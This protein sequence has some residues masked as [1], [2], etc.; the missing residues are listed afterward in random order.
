MTGNVMIII[1]FPLFIFKP[2]HSGA[3]FFQPPMLWLSCYAY[4]GFFFGL[5]RASRALGSAAVSGGCISVVGAAGLFYHPVT[6]QK[7]LPEMFFLPCALCRKG[8]R[9]GL[10]WAFAVTRLSL[11]PFDKVQMSWYWYFATRNKDKFSLSLIFLDFTVERYITGS[12]T[13]LRCRACSQL[14]LGR[15]HLLLRLPQLLRSAPSS[16]CMTI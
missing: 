11:P 3:P 16:R 15:W 7:Q 4:G 1:A 12:R 2:S 5:A 8:L 9:M 10:G 13:W 14:A 6:Q